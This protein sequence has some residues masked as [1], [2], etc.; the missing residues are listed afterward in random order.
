MGKRKRFQNKVV[1]KENMV[2]VSEFEADMQ[3]TNFEKLRVFIAAKD[4]SIK[5][6]DAVSQS[7][8]SPTYYLFN[9]LLRAADSV[10]ANIAEGCGRGSKAD[11]RRMIFIARGSMYETKYWIT[12]ALERKL[13][14]EKAAR[15]ILFDIENLIPQ[16]NA[17]INYL[18]K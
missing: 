13:I 4:I 15:E 9:Q 14:N 7:S 11:K 3:V 18:S 6:W 17:Y 8:K 10:G 5:I 2:V 16:I 1:M 12:L